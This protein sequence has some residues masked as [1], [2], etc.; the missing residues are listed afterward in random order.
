MGVSSWLAPP[1][2]LGGSPGLRQVPG[3]LEHLCR[4]PYPLVPLGS[5]GIRGADIL[6]KKQSHKGAT[7]SKVG[8]IND[9]VAS[10]SQRNTGI[11]GA[12]TVT[13]MGVGQFSEEGISLGFGCM[14]PWAKGQ[15]YHFR[16]LE[17]STHLLVNQSQEEPKPRG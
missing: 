10:R 6:L 1:E 5:S 11:S 2:G 9:P 14:R 13:G 17:A 7:K 8:F 4:L 3:E 16:L 15:A 12:D